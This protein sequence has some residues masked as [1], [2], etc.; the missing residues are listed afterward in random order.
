VTWVRVDEHF[1]N[2]PKVLALGRDRLA[3][4]GL[5]LIGLCYCNEY[6]TNGFIPEHMLPV[7]SV[8]LARRLVEAGLW[9]AVDG[10]YRMHD[11]DEYQPTRE[12]VLEK[13]AKTTE[14]V[15]RWR[16]NTT[17]RFGGNGVG[18]GVGNARTGPSRSV[19]I[20]NPPTPLSDEERAAAIAHNRSL[21]EET[22]D[23]AIAR[24]ARKALEK[25]GA[26]P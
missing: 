1:P 8:K 20:Y 10:G 14:R 7:R 24:A 16:D 25:L 19:V 3:G 2:H 5:W 22:Q 23:P 21:I 6:L 26:Q 18:N 12:Y 11:F 9:D 17:G 13:R 15:R 4:M